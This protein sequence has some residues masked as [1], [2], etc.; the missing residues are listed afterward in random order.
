M[1]NC[2]RFQSYIPLIIVPAEL[3]SCIFLPDTKSHRLSKTDQF[4]SDSLGQVATGI[5]P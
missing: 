4:F 2:P 3:S 1:V 5:W